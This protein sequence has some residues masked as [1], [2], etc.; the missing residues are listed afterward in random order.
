MSKKKVKK[1]GF[2]LAEDISITDYVKI[3]VRY[4]QKYKTSYT[5]GQF[6][7]K[8]NDG[9]IDIKKEIR[10]ARLSAQKG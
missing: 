6:I 3:I 5:Y 10:N 9:D 8:V 4:N 2:T 7:Q 1:K